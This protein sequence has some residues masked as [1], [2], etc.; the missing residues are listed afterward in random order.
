MIEVI[1]DASQIEVFEACPRKWFYDYVLN[2]TTKHP[3]PALSTGSYYH[4]ILKYYYSNKLD[5]RGALLMAQELANGPENNKWPAVGAEPQFHYERLKNYLI[6]YRDEDETDEVIAVEQG[7]STLLYE[8]ND[9]R[10]ILEGMIDYIGIRKHMGLTIRD[11]K[12]QSRAYEKYEINHQVFNY[13]SFTGANYFEYNYVGLQDKI[14]D[15]TFRRLIYKPHPGMLEQW[16]SDVRRT[17]D[18]MFEYKLKYLEVEDMYETKELAAYYQLELG[19]AFP[20]RRAACD[21]KFG[22]CQFKHICQVPDNSQWVPL[23]MSK[24][25]QKDNI[26]RAWNA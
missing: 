6:K 8:D 20:R 9:R 1:L 7:F 25:K 18:Q 4:E 3:N 5:L 2:L 15:A 19:E 17:F 23:V 22:I 11:H 12:T 14:T 13:M 21:G 10:Y 26:W 16:R 24:Y